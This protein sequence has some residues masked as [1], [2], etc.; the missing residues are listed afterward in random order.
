MEKEINYQSVSGSS[1]KA[2]IASPEKTSGKLPAIILIHEIFGLD[3]HFRDVSR[4]LAKEGYLVITP[5]LF[6]GELNKITSPQAIGTLLPLLRILPREH[7]GNPEKIKEVT[8]AL[9]EQDRQAFQILMDILVGKYDQRFV[10]DL[11]RAGDYLVE[12]E[13]ADSQKIAS[14]GFCFGGGMSGLLAVSDARMAAHIIFYGKRPPAEKISTIKAPVLGIYGS[15][16][17]G[18]TPTI[19]GLA[20]DMKKAGKNFEYVVYEGANHAFF[21]DTRKQVYDPEAAASS[22]ELVKSFLRNNLQ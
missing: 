4:R 13:N 5:H 18:I 10:D 21:N 16:D 8:A 6:S 3:E 22:W 20:E 2:F 1:L 11:K 14:M 9:S 7:F 12:N 17:A 19:A 15:L